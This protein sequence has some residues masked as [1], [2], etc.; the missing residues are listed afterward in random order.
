MKDQF[1]SDPKLCQHHQEEVGPV[2][3]HV[4]G[5]CYEKGAAS[6]PKVR[7]YGF[8]DYVADPPESFIAPRNKLLLVHPKSR[9]VAMKMI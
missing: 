3:V 6:P 8:E 2:P 5:P 7:Q 9:R 1:L 4:Q